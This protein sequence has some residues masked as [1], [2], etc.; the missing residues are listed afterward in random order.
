MRMK[1][2]LV[3]YFGY[4]NFGD[5]LMLKIISDYFISKG[6]IDLVILTKRRLDFIDRVVTQI[7]TEGNTTFKD[8]LRYFDKQ[9]YVVWCGGTCFYTSNDNIRGVLGVLKRVIASRVSGA[10]FNFIGIGVE[11]PT[12]ALYEVVYKTTFKLVNFVGIRDTNS[13]IV[14]NSML[15]DTQLNCDIAYLLEEEVGKNIG[16]ESYIT[17]S[18]AGYSES[19]ENIDR[20][21]QFLIEICQ[22]YKVKLRLLSLHDGIDEQFNES[23]ILKVYQ[24]I[25]VTHSKAYTIQDRLKILG[26]ARF[27]LGMRLHSV[28]LSDVLN[29]PVYSI[30]Y[31][32]KVN[33]YLKTTTMFK[34]ERCVDIKDNYELEKL[35]ISIDEQESKKNIQEF[36]LEEKKKMLKVIDSSVGI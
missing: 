14:T 33:E 34:F 35:I 27:N 10:K 28:I 31:Q 4:G 21:A 9:D 20:I 15:V 29:V 12:K 2:C 23:L 32:D 1:I 19:V 30:S 22:Y 11:Q 8:Y 6:N 26:S 18:P 13:K 16:T 24:D 36:I 25:D 5:D 7:E 17:F 3:G